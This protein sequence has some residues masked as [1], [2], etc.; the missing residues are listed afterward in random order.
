MHLEWM[1]NDAMMHQKV[2]YIHQ[3]PV[4]WGYVDKAEYWRYFSALQAFAWFSGGL[5]AMLNQ[6]CISTQE[7]AKR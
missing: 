4:N 6:V 1:Q 3:N 7:R 2:E 5:S